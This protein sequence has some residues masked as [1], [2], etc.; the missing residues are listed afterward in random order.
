MEAGKLAKVVA[1]MQ[2]KTI[3]KSKAR[4]TD[5]GLGMQLPKP[6]QVSRIA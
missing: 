2:L 4:N 5:L 1:N 3:N 6:V